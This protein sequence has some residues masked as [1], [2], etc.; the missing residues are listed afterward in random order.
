MNEELFIQKV[1]KLEEAISEI[2]NQISTKDDAPKFFCV[3]IKKEHLQI[4]E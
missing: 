2:K 1:I 3:W 4:F